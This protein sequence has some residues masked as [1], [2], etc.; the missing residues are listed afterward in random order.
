[1][2]K[3]KIKGGGE[4]NEPSLQILETSMWPFTDYLKSLLIFHNAANTFLMK[5][6]PK[7]LGTP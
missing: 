6:S 7:D 2:M 5:C 3:E 1:M 4:D